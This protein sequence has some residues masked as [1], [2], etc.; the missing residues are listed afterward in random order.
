VTAVPHDLSETHVLD[1]ESLEARVGTL[2][3]SYRSAKPFPHIVLEELL[4][5]DVAQRAADEFPAVDSERWNTHRHVNELKSND[6]E[7]EGWGPTLQ[8]VLA[9]LNSQR[10]VHFLSELT[11]I[12]DLLPDPSL[13]GG[14]LHQ[15]AR[16]GF[17]NVHADFTV[18]PIQRDWRRRV[19]ILVYFNDEWKPE[20]GGDL[21]LWATD[22]SR[23][24]KTVAPLVN[25]SVIFTTN[26]DSYHGHPEP[27]ACPPGMARRSLALYYFVIEP[28]AYVRSTEY[29]ARPGDGARGALIYADKMAL[30]GFDWAKRH[31]GVS[32]E[33]ALKVMDFVN[34]F[35]RKPSA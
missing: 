21:E 31:L 28:D 5:R 7:P 35:R 14:G 30:R 23:C 15:S 32:D 3:E 24:E 2:G 4:D 22:M 11:G 1:F 9:D 8:A 12:P 26:T 18:H 34:R 6:T 17:L 27:L 19:N 13:E 10:F 25:R 16:G 33:T 20:Y 29:R